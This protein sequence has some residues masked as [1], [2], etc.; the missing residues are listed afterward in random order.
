MSGTMNAPRILDST[1]N[2]RL[3]ESTPRR[4]SVSISLL[5]T[6]TS[7]FKPLPSS[8]EHNEISSLSPYEK[9]T[10]WKTAFEKHLNHIYLNKLKELDSLLSQGKDQID[11]EFDKIPSLKQSVIITNRQQTTDHT[12]DDMEFDYSNAQAFDLK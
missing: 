7:L 5:E 3:N 6:T 2:V 9:L 10:L 11:I 4:R 8:S 1:Q 12:Y